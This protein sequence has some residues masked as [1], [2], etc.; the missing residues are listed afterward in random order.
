MNGGRKKQGNY[1]GWNFLLD[2]GNEDF[3][4][5]T[6]LGEMGL[7]H[8]EPRCLLARFSF[9]LPPHHIDAAPSC[10]FVTQIQIV[11]IRVR[12]KKEKGKREDRINQRLSV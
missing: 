5:G 4:G 11:V 9:L 12:R 2:E 10:C 1:L 6:N 7:F 8:Q 3:N